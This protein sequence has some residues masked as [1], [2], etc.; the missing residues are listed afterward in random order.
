MCPFCEP[1][2][3]HIFATSALAYALWDAYPVSAGHALLLPK[4]H[5]EQFFDLTLEEKAALFHL[6]DAAREVLRERYRPDAFNVGINVGLAAGQTVQHA[7]VHL[8]PRYQ[9]DVEDPRG[10]VRGVI[11]KKRLY[12]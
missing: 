3:T 7:H 12:P 9:G 10:G 5:V 8:I 11:P 2:D 4:R 1:D 6:L